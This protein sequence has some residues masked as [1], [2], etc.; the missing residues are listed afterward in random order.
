MRYNTK[1][2]GLGL[3][4]PFFVSGRLRADRTSDPGA[5][6]FTWGEVVAWGGLEPPT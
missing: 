4:L 5:I 2:K 1:C 6:V 3:R